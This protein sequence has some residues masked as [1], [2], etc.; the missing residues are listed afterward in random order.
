MSPSRPSTVGRPA[1]V[2][3]DG[4]ALRHYR[5]RAGLSREALG[6]LLTV[7]TRTIQRLENEGTVSS[8]LLK[9][10]CE[11]LR[12]PLVGVLRAEPETVR[13]SL[14]AAGF[15]PA[16]A[17]VMLGRERERQRAL[18]VITRDSGPRVV[19]VQGAL[20]IG[21][22]CFA[23]A[24]A[25][26]VEERFPGGVIWIRGDF[27]Q[28]EQVQLDLA[29]ALGFDGRLPPSGSER[30]GRDWDQ[31]F[32]AQL[33]ER[34]RLVVLDDVV[35]A[36][37]VRAFLGDERATVIVTSRF[38]RV[39][40]E[41]DV[42]PLALGPLG[43]DQ[44]VSLFSTDLEP[45]HFADDAARAE[46]VALIGGCPGI[47]RT[48]GAMLRR[49]RLMPLATLLR[50]LREGGRSAGRGEFGLASFYEA[51]RPQLSEQAWALFVALGAFDTEPVT[52]TLAAQAAGMDH[53]V[54]RRAASELL[55]AHMLKLNNEPSLQDSE[56]W[57][58][59][60]T[61]AAIGAQALLGAHVV[62]V[63]RRAIH[64][65]AQTLRE[66][67]EVSGDQV[68]RLHRDH[69]PILRRVLQALVGS[70]PDPVA[71]LQWGE[72][73]NME[74]ADAKAAMALLREIA[75]MVA[76]SGDAAARVWMEVG[77]VA[78]QT[79]NEPADQG[80]AEILAAWWLTMH[81]GVEQ[82]RERFEA[83]LAAL[84]R[85]GDA[86]GEAAA[87]QILAAF[88]A[89][90]SEDEREALLAGFVGAAPESPRGSDD[91]FKLEVAARLTHTLS[92]QADATE[93]AADLCGRALQTL[94][95][96]AEPPPIQLAATRLWRDTYRAASRPS[97]VAAAAV[98]GSLRALAI[99]LQDEW[100]GVA[101]DAHVAAQ[102][103]GHPD[104]GRTGAVLRARTRF[105]AATRECSPE[106]APRLLLLVA[107]WAFHYL[108]ARL[109]PEHPALRRGIVAH[110][111]WLTGG[112]PPIAAQLGFDA[113]LPLAL[114]ATSALLDREYVDLVV[115]VARNT[116]EGRGF[117]G[118]L[119]ALRD[120]LDH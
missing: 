46:L 26:E 114:E 52:L 50:R 73:P 60:E 76:M 3:V 57:L 87:L 18:E 36:A 110:G 100:L 97:R 55:D 59:L 90:E 104:H 12:A 20:G 32:A 62:E 64:G 77:L 80:L 75:P 102:A 68:L 103:R 84:R 31:V 41:L 53:D 105:F 101:I 10:I 74:V 107:S 19:V 81:H 78:A 14:R 83:S 47:A 15:G 49:D 71:P 113:L 93:R 29:R 17:P 95:Q 61:N 38:Q 118:L 9:R 27:V 112:R 11:V 66:A 111:L 70:W 116:P 51:I 92:L 13:A 42:T 7:T 6:E 35:E 117:M 98:T 24:I 99:E 109:H 45:R 8:Q 69:Q 115:E 43:D 94:E 23:L 54:A 37:Q 33:W 34:R 48:I 39:A 86:V 120:A 85:A 30:G 40:D 22:S 65:L 119:G 106:L 67:R 79:T 63:R 21:K 16:P 5:E 25:R 96:M 89:P 1:A 44:V 4:A 108:L 72:A 91:A 56:P 82:G 88:C 28:P 2:L 58:V